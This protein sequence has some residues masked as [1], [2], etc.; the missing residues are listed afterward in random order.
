MPGGLSSPGT[1]MRSCWSTAAGAATRAATFEPFVNEGRDGHDVVVWLADQPWCNGAVTM[2]GGSYAGFNQWMTLKES[3]PHLKT[4]VPAAS[5]HAA[6][7]FPFFKNI[8]YPTR[9]SG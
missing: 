2:W 3:P 1:G 7:D 9:C 8:F 6:V 5:A 4:I